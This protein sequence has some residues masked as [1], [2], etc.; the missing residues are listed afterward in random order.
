MK[1]SVVIPA[2]NRASTLPSCLASVIGQTYPPDEIIVVD[3]RS[4]DETAQIV[5]QYSE[6]GV[7]YIRLHQSKG[8]QTARNF[9]VC[10]ARNNWIAF[11]DSDDL[12]LPNKLE[13]Q[14]QALSDVNFDPNAVVHCNAYRLDAHS[15][16][17][18][19]LPIGE[20]SGK[21]YKKLLLTSGP[22]FPGLLVSKKVL[23]ECGMLDEDCPSYQEWDT[24]I[25]LAKAC[26]FIHIAEPLFDWVWH[27]GET[28]SKDMRRDIIG[29]QYVLDKHKA[30]IIT[31]HGDRAWR[32][33]KLQNIARALNASLWQD[34]SEMI[35]R[36]TWHPSFSLAKLFAF[37]H[38]APRGVGLLLRL[39]A[40]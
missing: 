2:R 31:L 13:L 17:R 12:W 16:E 36:E 28:I 6:Q 40:L 35:E 21:C 4:T 20:F 22:M 23:S 9:G 33:A 11:Q 27:D 1:I 24:A 18:S 19:L 30:A 38:V 37:A 26:E 15:G 10:N 3:D 32:R 5:Q 8:A 29:Y 39:A 34:A 7:R 25:R 14:V